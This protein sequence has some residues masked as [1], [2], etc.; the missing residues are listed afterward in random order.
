MSEVNKNNETPSSTDEM[1]AMEFTG[2]RFV[3]E[4]H[5]GIELEHWHRYLKA[6]EL[7]QGKDVLDIASGEGYGSA[8]LAKVAS[9]VVGVDISSDAVAH[10]NRRYCHSNLRFL[11]GSCSAIPLPDNSVDMIVSFETI[12]HHDQHVEMMREFKRVLRSDGLLIISSPDKYFYSQVP[13]YTNV[14]HLKELYEIEFKTLIAT[15]FERACYFGQ[16][17]AYG[18]VI[19]QE[20]GQAQFAHE[21]LDGDSIRSVNALP[22]PQYWI[23]IASDIDL[24]A[25]SVGIFEQ[26]LLQSEQLAQWRQAVAQQQKLL[27]LR[28]E[29]I[30]NYATTNRNI[31]ALLENMTQE[32][33][34][35]R[36]ELNDIKA[37]KYWRISKHLRKIASLD[38]LLSGQL[39]QFIKV[40]IYELYLIYKKIPL[41]TK[42]RNSIRDVLFKNLSQSDTFLQRTLK[43][44]RLNRDRA[45]YGSVYQEF[46]WREVNISLPVYE[47]PVV[48]VIVPVYG[49]SNY[50]LRCLASIQRHLPDVP[51]EVIVIDDCSVD[52]TREI[53]SVVGGIHLIC[54]ETNLGFIRSCNIGAANARGQY[55]H[56]LNNDT[57][58]TPGW[59]DSLLLTFELFSET[60]FVGSK[61]V[62][63][64]GDLQEAGGLIWRDG[65]AW[66]FGHNQDQLDPIYCYAREVDYCSG[67]S[68]MVPASLFSELGGFDEVYVPAYCEDSDLALRIR[69]KGYRVIY[70]PQSV[71]VHYEGI[72]NGTNLNQSVKAYQLVNMRKQFERWKDLLDSYQENGKDV[73]KAKDRS[74]SRRVLVLDHCTP[75]PDHDA[76][77]LLC[78]NLM[79]I[80]REMGFQVTFIPEDN[81]A[82]ITGYTDE[83]QS[84]G[85]EVLYEPYCSTVKSHLERYGYRY[86]LAVL[87][88]PVV[89]DR[90]ENDIRHYC[91]HAKIIYHTVDLHYLRM[92]R[93]S[94]LLVGEVSEAAAKMKALELEMIRKADASI[95]VSHVEK[96]LLDLE[97]SDQLVFVLPLIMQAPGTKACFSN[98]RDIVFVGGYQHQPNVDAVIYFVNEVMPLIQQKLPKVIFH[99]VGSNMPKKLSELANERVRV[100]G[101]VEDLESFLH[102]IRVNV[103]PIRYGAGIKGK[104]SGAMALGLPSVATVVATE[105]MGLSNGENILEANDTQDMV[106]KICI[107]YSDEDLWNR[108]SDCGIHYAEQS[109]GASAIYEQLAMLLNELGMP[110]R[111]IKRPLHTWKSRKDK[112]ATL[113]D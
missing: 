1:L 100:H 109:W 55:L 6:Q 67:A 71:V 2:E 101:F 13:N 106:E 27:D 45:A 57:E 79:L 89:M 44:K 43:L 94:V 24:P 85:V 15:W 80:M 11:Q 58:V 110:V 25:I 32:M 68:I 5:G 73:D 93:E 75:T 59:L 53:L 86:D 98:R 3:P 66:N 81:F 42:V 37:S 39:K 95:V 18:S 63:P 61:L 48:T 84:A 46:P 56:F 88:R 22:R 29:E 97:L 103:A 4:F 54:N 108:I 47:R 34:M 10:A 65:S 107:L 12:E 70:Q 16:R 14:H 111:K 90:H 102:T 92:Q 9:N 52:Q 60:G 76:G 21:E 7:A 69:S 35:V 74:A 50:T 105:G 96:S 91:P 87:F 33:H 23:A 99:I 41:S 30:K 82:Y 26:D 104:I 19:F 78:F 77:S 28:K 17:L 62:Y 20:S 36:V 64:N 8:L 31:Q 72:S 51:F 38:K 113:M 40:V 49:N 83:L 112:N